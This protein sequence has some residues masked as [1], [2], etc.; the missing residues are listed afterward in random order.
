MLK[1]AGLS[2]RQIMSVM[3]LEK[4]INHSFLPFFEKDVRNFFTKN[5]KKYGVN[6]V[7]DLLE[8]CKVAKEENC[9][10]Q[11]VFI[12]DNETKLEHIFWSRPILLIGTKNMG[13]LLYL[14][15]LT[16][17]MHTKCLLAF[18]L[19]STTMGRQ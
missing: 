10:F 11:Y 14:T 12:V 7:K 17:L 15:L 13:M 4:N 5:E 8:H 18:L 19:E 3:E 9:N 6:D 1:E 2:V 16:K